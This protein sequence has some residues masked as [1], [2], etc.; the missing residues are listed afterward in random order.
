M[1]ENLDIQLVNWEITEDEYNEY[2]D[3]LAESKENWNIQWVGK[4]NM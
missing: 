3:N 4:N 2:L 1:L